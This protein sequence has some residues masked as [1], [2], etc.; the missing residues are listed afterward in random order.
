MQNGKLKYNSDVSLY[1]KSMMLPLHTKTNVQSHLTY[2]M[3]WRIFVKLKY[4]P[5]N[6]KHLLSTILKC[7]T[8][9]SGMICVLLLLPT[10]YDEFNP[11]INYNSPKKK[12]IVKTG[13]KDELNRQ[14]NKIYREIASWSLQ[15]VNET[16]T[17]PKLSSLNDKSW[18][19]YS[20]NELFS[21]NEYPTDFVHDDLEKLNSLSHNKYNSSFGH[22]GKA[23]I[24]PDN[25][26]KKS[27]EKM[28]LHQL[29]VVASDIM[30]LNRRLND[31][32]PS[33]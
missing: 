16:I 18:L 8:F 30:S 5:I 27:K 7:F 20:K 26:A 4:N 15:A 28:S 31:M 32:R 13:F 24:L 21:W 11:R 14:P 3:C 2:S 17:L 10:F 19:K 23:V 12:L 9:L 6:R 22:L 25:L 1:H 29:N 33:R